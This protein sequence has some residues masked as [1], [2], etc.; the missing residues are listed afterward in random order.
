MSAYAQL[1]GKYFCAC[2]SYKMGDIYR[3]TCNGIH[4]IRMLI[5]AIIA[6]RD[7][8]N[9]NQFPVPHDFDLLKDRFENDHLGGAKLEKAVQKISLRV[10]RSFSPSVVFLWYLKPSQQ[11]WNHNKEKMKPRCESQDLVVLNSFFL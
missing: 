5:P 11:H 9:T 10:Y 3:E 7:C 6:L 4:S 1:Q 8:C 2:L